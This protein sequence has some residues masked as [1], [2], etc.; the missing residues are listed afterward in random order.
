VRLLTEQ[1]KTLAVAEWATGGRMS[2]FLTEATP[3]SSSPFLAGFGVTSLEQLGQ[4]LSESAEEASAL[5]AAAPHDLVV[6]TFA[7]EAVRR[8]TGADLG[9]AVA[10]F[11]PIVD[12][13]DSRVHAAIAMAERTRRLRFPCA[14]HPAIRQARAAKQAL[15]A[16]RLTLLGQRVP[17][18]TP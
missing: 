12:A 14:A 5:R 4:I 11:P 7:A 6:A 10:A 1:D 9:L 17:G 15:N 8:L 16:L 3:P 13:P 2:Q 18:E